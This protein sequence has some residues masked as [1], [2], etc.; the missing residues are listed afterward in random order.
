M[1]PL[2]G[3]LAD[4]TCRLK[5]K[6]GKR[7]SK[8][9]LSL[10]AWL[11]SVTGHA[12]TVQ[13]RI[14]LNQVGF[15][16]AAPKIAVVTGKTDAK[17]FF[18]TSPDG[19]VKLFTGK[20]SDEKP[21]RYSS[22]ITRTADFSAFTKKGRYV[23]SVPGVAT[24][25]AFTIGDNVHDNA[26][27]TVL[28]AFYFI[29]SDMPLE[30]K[31][32]GK[33]NRPAGHPDTAVLVHPSAATEQRP[34][35][36]VLS[37]P[38]GWYD[39]GDYNKY[40]VNS[41]ITMG[42]LLSAYEDF[43]QYFSKL[44]VVIPEGGNDVPDILNEALYNLR[45]M[46]TM[47]DP[48]DGGVY[49]KL[50]NAAFDGMVM[51]GVT[52]LPRYVV[53]K[54]TAATLDFAAVTAQAAR[55]L[56]KFSKQFPGLADSCRAAAVKAWQWAEKNPAVI[57]SQREINPKYDPDITTG[58][59]GDRNFKDEWLWAAAELFAT[60]KETIYLSVVQE[61]MKDPAQLPSW[62]NVAMLGYYTMIRMEN[63]LPAAKATIAA[64]KD[65]VLKIATTYLSNVGANA[66][67]TVMGQ[68]VKDFS[69]GGNSVAANQGILL[70]RAYLLTK[71][72]NYLDGALTNLD[73]ILGR[74]ATGYSFVT[75]IGSKRVMHPHH[76]PSEADGIDDPVPGLLSGGPN[77]GMQDKCQY[78]SA[79]PEL[80]YVDSVCSY[81]SN[82]IAINWQAPM[83]YLACAIEALQKELK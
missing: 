70:L 41:G 9:V 5:E 19:R 67:A 59:Y 65:T 6:K 30:K 45:W 71:N 4:N 68:N 79:E 56:Q 60:T 12:Q 44:N 77:P 24:S 22:T 10:C 32:A 17:T 20:L 1:L 81:A 25:Y 33:W 73:Y 47:Q 61:R 2:S 58:E 26:A 36:T 66:F 82:E 53:Q 83:V 3:R 18:I 35:G 14:Q 76:R 29:R 62:G 48:A 78:P 8:N 31:F 55:I 43:P 39:A 75:G 72:K 69:W 27:K 64:M 51:P 63:N 11:V 54:G 34:A 42:T 28:K 74:N 52:K 57:Y 15:Y 80:A 40:I 21:S 13:E 49:H 7:L 16:P 37:S 38:G 50:T 23:V 46:L